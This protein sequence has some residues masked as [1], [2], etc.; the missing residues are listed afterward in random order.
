MSSKYKYK[1][2]TVNKKTKSHD[3]V[4]PAIKV[5]SLVEVKAPLYI[6]S[7][8]NTK[9]EHINEMPSED[10]VLTPEREK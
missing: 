5:A 6:C 8:E 3:A 1:K 4:Y 7:P 2:D 10:V 9:M